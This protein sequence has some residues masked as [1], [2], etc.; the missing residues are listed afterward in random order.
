VPYART[1]RTF[2]VLA[3][4]VVAASLVVAPLV[5]AG[6]AAAPPAEP[7]PATETSDWV[8][9][10]WKCGDAGVAQ[11]REVVTS[12]HGV[13]DAGEPTAL[14]SLTTETRN[15]PF[16]QDE[17]AQCRPA[18]RDSSTSQGDAAHRADSRMLPAAVVA[19]AADPT[20]S[21]VERL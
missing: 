5:S 19:E 1:E 6:A 9:G 21:T 18:P 8:D 12:E 11:T 17:I 16:T 7:V 15:R 3:T 13:D 14:S 20:A 10:D 2:S 4:V